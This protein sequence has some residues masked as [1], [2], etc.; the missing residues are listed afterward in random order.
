MGEWVNIFSHH[1]GETCRVNGEVIQCSIN[2]IY[3][4]P[5]PAPLPFSFNNVDRIMAVLFLL[6]I[7]S[8]IIVTSELVGVGWAAVKRF[9]RW[10]NSDIVNS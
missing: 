9:E 8:S 6:F 7:L 5:S 1:S 4:D 3:S 10:C 2:G